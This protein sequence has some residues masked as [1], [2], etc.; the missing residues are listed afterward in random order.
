MYTIN[1]LCSWTHTIYMYLESIRNVILLTHTARVSFT[2]L[3]YFTHAYGIV[4]TLF[5]VFISIIL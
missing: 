3:Y 4:S 1:G 5:D 2:E